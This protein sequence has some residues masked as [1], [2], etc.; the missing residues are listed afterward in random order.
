MA[1]YIIESIQYG[2]GESVMADHPDESV[3]VAEI[4][5]RSE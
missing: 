1:D 5:V 2:M 3:I 4:R